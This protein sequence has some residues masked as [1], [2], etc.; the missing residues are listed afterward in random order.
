MYAV[1][2][3]QGYIRGEIRYQIPPPLSKNGLLCF[4]H[5]FAR[6]SYPLKIEPQVLSDSGNNNNNNNNNNNAIKYLTIIK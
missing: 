6:V 5:T 3:P 4:F 2:T 1:P